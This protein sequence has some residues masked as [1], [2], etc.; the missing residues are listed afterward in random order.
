MRRARRRFR[1]GCSTRDCVSVR[2]I[3]KIVR[4]RITPARE[5]C[6]HES[7]IADVHVHRLTD[8]AGDLAGYTADLRVQCSVCGTRFVF[9][10]VQ[11]GWSP[12]QPMANYDRTELHIPLAPSQPRPIRQFD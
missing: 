7:F 6:E 5:N 4:A 1:R 2:E 9:D 8:D 12:K 10:G 11:Q 3:E